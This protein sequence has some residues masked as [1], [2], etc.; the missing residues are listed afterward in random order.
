MADPNGPTDVHQADV[1]PC[2][3]T[4][5][6]KVHHQPGVCRGC[7]AEIEWYETVGG[8]SMPM[9]VGARAVSVKGRE[10]NAVLAFAAADTHWA[11]CPGAKS[12][13]KKRGEGDAGK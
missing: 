10:K 13:K 12:F 5:W 9:N 8:R 7:L 3:K 4:V 2:P 11:T 1:A 6:L